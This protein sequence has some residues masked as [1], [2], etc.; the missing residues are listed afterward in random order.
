[1]SAARSN[2]ATATTGIASPRDPALCGRFAPT[3]SGPLHFG[4]L[5]AAAGSYL[6]VRSRGGRWLLRIDDLDQARCIPGLATQF[7]TTLETFGFEWD[8]SVHFQSDRIETYASAVSALQ[9]G[10]HCYACRCSRAAI[11]A[12][13]TADPASEPIYPGTC[14]EDP[15]AGTQPHALRFRIDPDD[16]VVEYVDVFQGPVRQDCRREAGDFVI[17][18]RDGPFAYHLA[19]VVDDE[20]QG[21]TEIVRGADLLSS[22]PRQI[23]LQRSLGYRTPRYGHLPLLT[24]PD[25]QKLAKSRRAVPLEAS[26]APRQLWQVL[27]WLEQSP[28]AAL[29]RAPVREIWTWAI[30]NWQPERLEG[31]RER[32]LEVRQ[33]T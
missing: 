2:T 22:T 32:R 33:E 26:D 28:P 31:R 1:V 24:E 21:V 4:S 16:A 8:G 19:V 11:A 7:Q 20:L 14:R 15:T 30:A 27:N 25:G 29:L 17:Q 6:N 5:L 23:L 3:P 9:A 12:A 10:K 13:H 18:R